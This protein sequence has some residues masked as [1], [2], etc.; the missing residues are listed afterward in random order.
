MKHHVFFCLENKIR[1]PGHLGRTTVLHFNAVFIIVGGACVPCTEAVLQQ[2]PG[3]QVQPVLHVILSLSL[4]LILFPLMSQSYPINKAM[5][6][7][8]IEVEVS[9][10]LDVAL[11]HIGISIIFQSTVQP[12]S[13]ITVLSY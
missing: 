7:P 1:R 6:R 5:K 12:S 11:S 13:R 4:S 2:C 3:V 10:D 9:C 8:K